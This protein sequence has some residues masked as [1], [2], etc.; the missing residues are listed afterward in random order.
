MCSWNANKTS[1]TEAYCNIRNSRKK[2]QDKTKIK[3][4]LKHQSI[5]KCAYVR[6]EKYSYCEYSLRVEIEA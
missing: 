5:E 2:K 4:S 6:N 1:Y 3:K